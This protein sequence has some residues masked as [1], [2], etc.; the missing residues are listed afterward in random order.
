MQLHKFDIRHRT[1][2]GYMRYYCLRRGTLTM[3]VN[4][5]MVSYIFYISFATNGTSKL[6]DSDDDVDDGDGDGAVE[7]QAPNMPVHPVEREVNNDQV[8]QRVAGAAAPVGVG[9]PINRRRAVDMFKRLIDDPNAKAADKNN[10][11]NNIDQDQEDKLVKAKDPID[12]EAMA[13]EKVVDYNMY[14]E[15]TDEKR[16]RIRAIINTHDN[17]KDYEKIMHNGQWM[18]FICCYS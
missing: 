4:M 12:N 5:L 14:N 8:D 3:L 6:P 10:N 18:T 11:D 16:K 9:V 1:R 17:I 2:M 7:P 13:M 15:E